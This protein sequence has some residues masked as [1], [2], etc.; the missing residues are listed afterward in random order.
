[1]SLL[2]SAAV[3]VFI[4]TGRI[5][6]INKSIL[7]NI[8]L[9]LIMSGTFAVLLTQQDKHM[10]APIAFL[11]FGFSALVPLIYCR[12]EELVNVNCAVTA[13]TFAAAATGDLWRLVSLPATLQAAGSMAAAL[14]AILLFALLNRLA[15]HNIT[16]R[17]VVKR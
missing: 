11:G 16:T 15:D 14:L 6:S 9:L 7:I 4:L 13:C 5:V 12:L 8:S 2:I 1:M 17:P 10:W 3:V